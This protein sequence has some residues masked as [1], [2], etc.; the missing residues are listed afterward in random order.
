MSSIAFLLD[1]LWDSCDPADFETAEQ[2]IE[3]CELEGYA[4]PDDLDEH[5]DTL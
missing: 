4:V 5:Y 1:S 2:V 3:H